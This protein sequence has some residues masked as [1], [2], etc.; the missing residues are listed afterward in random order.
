MMVLPPLAYSA[1]SDWRLRALARPLW[2]RLD[3][4]GL[5]EPMMQPRESSPLWVWLTLGLMTAGTVTYVTGY[6]VI[7]DLLAFFK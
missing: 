2:L 6:F 4:S 1:R 7:E 5:R 3:D